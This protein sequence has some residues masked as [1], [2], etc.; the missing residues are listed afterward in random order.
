MA[1]NPLIS[2]PVHMTG[3]G[4]TRASAV[5]IPPRSWPRRARRGHGFS[6]AVYQP[7]RLRSSTALRSSLR[8]S[9]RPW[10]AEARTTKTAKKITTPRAE[11]GDDAVVGLAD[12]ALAVVAREGGRGQHEGGRDHDYRRE[13]PHPDANDTRASGPAEALAFRRRVAVRG[14]RPRASRRGSPSSCRSRAPVTCGSFPP[15]PAG[16]TRAPRSRRSRSSGRW[17]PSC[18]TSGTTSPHCARLAALGARPRGAPRARRAAR[19]VHPA[20]HDPD[21]DLRRSCSRTRSRPGRATST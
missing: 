18:S 5:Q 17:P 10:R 16:R 12:E 20:R 21:R 14:N 19:L 8:L 1:T 3:R 13:E 6:G 7:T 15:S 2:Q 4:G 9:S 11:E